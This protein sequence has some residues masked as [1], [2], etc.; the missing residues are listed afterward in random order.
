MISKDHKK[1]IDCGQILKINKTNFDC[2]IRES[3]KLYFSIRC[4]PCRAIQ[5]KEIR[6]RNIHHY[7]AQ[8]TKRRNSTKYAEGRF[9][10]LGNYGWTN[11][12]EDKIRSSMSW[13]LG[14]K[15]FSN[16]WE[17]KFHRLDTSFRTSL[18]R[19]KNHQNI[20]KKPKFNNLSNVKKQLGFSKPFS[21]LNRIQKAKV[22]GLLL[23]HNASTNYSAKTY[24][25]DVN[26]WEKKFNTIS[27]QLW[28]RTET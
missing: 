3:G 9:L 11:G 1:C 16:K 7:R 27:F 18:M 6:N 28:Q 12:A 10:D 8:A 21:E 14:N 2:R 25:R 17:K 24:Q 15:E 22:L 4:K 5:K 20:K 19:R 23:I 13:I 26:L